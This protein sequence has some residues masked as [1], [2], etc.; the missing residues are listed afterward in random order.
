MQQEAPPSLSL[1]AVIEELDSFVYNGAGFWRAQALELPIITAMRLV[2]DRE[3]LKPG[4]DARSEAIESAL[5]AAISELQEPT[6]TAAEHFFGFSEECRELKG[7]TARGGFA[8]KALHMDER[9]FRRKRRGS[10]GSQTPAAELIE[11]VGKSLIKL[12]QDGPGPGGDRRPT[13]LYV[14]DTDAYTTIARA[15]LPDYEVVCVDTL[16]KAMEALVNGGPF[17]L[18]LVDPNL[19]DLEEGDGLE[20]LEYLRERMPD[21]PRVVVTGS[22]FAGAI[23]KNLGERY[24]VSEILIKGDYTLPDLRSTVDRAVRQQACKEA[25]KKEGKTDE[26]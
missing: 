5:E 20:V 6:R 9:S 21:T 25:D 18:V 7:K 2:T 10:A 12:E 15:A 8:A 1:A 22:R 11:A 3:G 24:G 14:E 16:G 19:T 4:P 26:G 13:L 17:A 23:T